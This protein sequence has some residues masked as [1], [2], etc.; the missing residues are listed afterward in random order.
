M[1]PTQ[2]PES[3]AGTRDDRGRFRPGTSGNPGGR[4]PSLAALIRS[5]TRDG[6]SLVSFLHGVVRDEKAVVRDRI[7][8]CEM[9]LTF[10]FSKPVATM[11]DLAGDAAE[12]GERPLIPVAVLQQWLAG[13]QGVDGN[14][15][16][17]MTLQAARSLIADSE[18][19]VTKYA[20]ELGSNRNGGDAG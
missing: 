4:R 10:G 20:A 6:A 1:T 18:Q 2:A 13:A 12:H 19:N 14:G 3:T 9:L 8:A 5:R 15:S 7:R 17:L 11:L 16:R